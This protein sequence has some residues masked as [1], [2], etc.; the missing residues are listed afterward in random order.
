[1][2]F[3]LDASLANLR[4]S[5]FEATFKWAANQ[6]LQIA[7]S[8]HRRQVG[9]MVP[10]FTKALQESIIQKSTI[11]VYPH[12]YQTEF[13]FPYS[14]TLD[15]IDLLS[16]GYPQLS[17]F[18]SLFQ[19]RKFLDMQEKHWDQKP[20]FVKPYLHCHSYSMLWNL[21]RDYSCLVNLRSALQK[22]F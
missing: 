8:Y 1:M 3:D 20:P 12:F 19:K 15:S 7:S 22:R 10:R 21:S 9:V 17:T 4:I 13:L 18:N 14:I 2:V 11:Q 6:M 5:A 16:A